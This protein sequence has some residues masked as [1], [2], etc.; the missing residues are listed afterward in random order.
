M[1]RKRESRRLQR[2]AAIMFF[3]VIMGMA[4][5]LELRPVAV[6][7]GSMEPVI[8]TGSVCMISG[9]DRSGASGKIIA[10]ELQD[11]LVIHR[12]SRYGG[13]AGSYITKG[14]SN[15]AEDP[16]PVFADQIR[17]TVIG[18]VPYLGYAALF[19]RSTKGMM[20]A[21]CII[22]FLGFVCFPGKERV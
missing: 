5:L 3:L 20:T 9:A 22:F 11:H 10:Y 16:A 8:S 4:V 21:A 14:D 1:S 19:L 12:I 18:T 13:A 17:G 2:I 7:S 6:L 15:N